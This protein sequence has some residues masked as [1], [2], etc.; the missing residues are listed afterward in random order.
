MGA[1]SL[2]AL[3]TAVVGEAELPREGHSVDQ[4]SLLLDASLGAAVQLSHHYEVML[5]GHVQL[6]QPYAAI[7]FGEQ[8]VASL[9]R[10]NLLLTLTFGVWP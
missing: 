3:H 7:R 4:W 5:A 8:Q 1:L 2:G 9:G 10:P 6:A